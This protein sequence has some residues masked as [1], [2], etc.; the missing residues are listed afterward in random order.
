MPPAHERPDERIREGEEVQGRQPELR[1]DLPAH[2]AER[3]AL[4]QERRHLRVR[5]EEPAD[6]GEH[7]AGELVHADL[8]LGLPE[9]GPGLAVLDPGGDQRDPGR[10]RRLQ[11]SRAQARSGGSIRAISGSRR[12]LEVA[13]GTGTRALSLD[14]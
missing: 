2:W 1:A 14:W 6:G 11:V 10:A 12:R 9:L 13:T 5:A 7:V 8:R 3:G 4:Q